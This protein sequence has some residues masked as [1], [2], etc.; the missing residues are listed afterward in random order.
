[1]D[2]EALR[3]T[4]YRN[5]VLG[6][7]CQNLDG[8]VVNGPEHHCLPGT[9]NVS[10]AWVNSDALIVAMKDV[11]VATGAACS[12]ASVT[13]SHV[14]QALGVS[15]DRLRSS[16]RFSMGRFATAGEVERVGESVVR[17]VKELRMSKSGAASC[18]LDPDSA[19]SG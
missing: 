2:E 16:I 9:L 14:L 4:E 18:G 7:L 3:L 13:P 8:V 19:P 10:F 6:A 5:R 11:A 15:S 17:A 1:M 12:S